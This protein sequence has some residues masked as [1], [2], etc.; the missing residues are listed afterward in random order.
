MSESYFTDDTAVSKP[1][2][3]YPRVAAFP[4]ATKRLCK[5]SLRV[6]KCGW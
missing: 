1:V 3:P 4:Y 6:R 5:G 2:K